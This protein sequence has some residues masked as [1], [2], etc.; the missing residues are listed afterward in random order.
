MKDMTMVVAPLAIVIYFICF[1]GQLSDLL[2]W[3]VAAAR[4]VH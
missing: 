4:Y 3:V 2:E 1:P